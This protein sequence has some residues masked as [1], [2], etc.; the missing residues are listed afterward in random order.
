M[1][2][3]ARLG[4]GAAASAFSPASS[5]MVARLA[6]GKKAGTYFGRYGSWKSLGYVIG[7]LLGRA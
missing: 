7:P 2:G 3:L 1:L 4:Q 6:G 5:A